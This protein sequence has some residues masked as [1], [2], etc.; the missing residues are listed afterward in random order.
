MDWEFNLIRLPVAMM[1]RNSRDETFF[2]CDVSPPKIGLDESF[3]NLNE[4]KPDIFSISYN[5]GRSVSV[6]SVVAASWVQAKTGISAMFTVGTRDMNKLA[7]QSLM[8]GAQ[9]NSLKNVVIVAG[10]RFSED[11]SP[12]VQEVNDFSPTEMIK[13]TVDMNSRKDFRGRNIHE[14]TEFC[15]GGVLDLNKRWDKEVILVGK[16][17]KAGVDFLLAQPFSEIGIAQEF[18]NY[19]FEVHSQALDLPILWGIQMLEKGS[20]SFYD[21]PEDVLRIIAKGNSGLDLSLSSIEEFQRIGIK[22]FYLIPPF[23]KGGRRNYEVA[24]SLIEEVRK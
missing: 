11:D 13:A 9:L 1:I 19:Y 12:S 6:N 4:L 24:Q 15:I 8:L 21:V 18:M 16:K 22:S 10:D 3:Q 23:Y 17:V 5:P 7:L 20:G 2:A 14:P